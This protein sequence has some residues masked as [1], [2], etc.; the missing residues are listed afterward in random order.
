M[1][2][3]EAIKIRKYSLQMNIGIRSKSLT[4]V[5]DYDSTNLIPSTGK[6]VSRKCQYESRMWRFGQVMFLVQIS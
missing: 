4:D 2:V 6:A 3:Q 5:C 1:N